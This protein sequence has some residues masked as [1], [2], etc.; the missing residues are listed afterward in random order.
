M[1]ISRCCLRTSD[2]GFADADRALE[3]TA[4]SLRTAAVVW[5]KVNL[6]GM[7]VSGEFGNFALPED[8]MLDEAIVSIGLGLP[9]GKDLSDRPRVSVAAKGNA[10]ASCPVP[11]PLAF[12]FNASS[13]TPVEFEGTIA[14]FLEAVAGIGLERTGELGAESESELALLTNGAFGLTIEAKGADVVSR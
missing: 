6:M 2:K 10:F 14:A 7:T 11:E 13:R 12:G 1:I 9:M 4:F 3:G 5:G 8:M